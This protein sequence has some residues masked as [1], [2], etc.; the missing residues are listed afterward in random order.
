MWE[1]YLEEKQ[2]SHILQRLVTNN[3]CGVDVG[4]HIGS[5]LSLLLKYA[6]QGKHIAVEASKV[7]SQW[8][9]RRFPTV[10]IV[11]K[12]VGDERLVRTWIS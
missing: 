7:K 1:L 4:S 5:F 11:S 3:S 8:L 12:A 9:R 10:E 6:P 2:I